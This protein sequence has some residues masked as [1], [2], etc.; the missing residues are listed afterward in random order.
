MFYFDCFIFIIFLIV[1]QDRSSRLIIISLRHRIQSMNQLIL[2]LFAP[3]IF[4]FENIVVHEGIQKAVSVVQSIYSIGER[5]LPSLFLFGPHGTGKTHILKAV[6]SRLEE[7]SDRGIRPVKF[8]SPIGDPPLFK[9][10]ERL[11]AEEEVPTQ[12]ISGAVIDDVHFIDR[13]SAANLWNLA[14]KLTRYGA[15]LIMGSLYSPEEVFEDNPHLKSRVTSGLVF[16]LDVPEDSI[17]ILILDKMA[18]DRNVRL[19]HDVAHYLVTR[20][21]RNV[22]EL[23]RLLDILDK[24]SLQLKRRITLPLVRMLEQEGMF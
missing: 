17:R 18:R 24:E 3:P 9:D 2:P 7:R 16:T 23:S 10:L 1:F 6:A 5:P 8:I 19:P 20:K 15:P 4:T 21:S 13:D 12:E 11:T 22:K 14:N